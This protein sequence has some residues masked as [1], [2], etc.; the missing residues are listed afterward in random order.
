MAVL[1]IAATAPRSR[2]R[3]RSCRVARPD[4]RRFDPDRGASNAPPEE[5]SGERDDP[6]SLRPWSPKE[7]PACCGTG[8][9]SGW[10]HPGGARAP[11]L[12]VEEHNV[13]KWRT[14]AVA[15]PILV[16]AVAFPW[17]AL[18]LCAFLSFQGLR[19]FAGLTG[20]V[21][22]RAVLLWGAGLAGPSAAALML[23]GAPLAYPRCSSVPRSRRWVSLGSAAGFDDPRSPSSASPTYRPVELLADLRNLVGGPGIL[24]TVF[25]LLALSDVC[26]FVWGRVWDAIR[27]LPG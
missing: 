1:A 3:R 6:A 14:W 23:A 22:P 13:A 2:A 27:S 26:A 18:A 10:D 9:C 11:R 5:G 15:L 20:S 16:L 8:R 19:E 21:A 4:R 17:G 25:R 24:L 12:A 7:H